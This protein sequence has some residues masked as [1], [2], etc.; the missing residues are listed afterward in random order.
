MEGQDTLKRDC[1]GNR[2]L[3]EAKER[4]VSPE[5]PSVARQRGE[6]AGVVQGGGDQMVLSDRATELRLDD[7]PSCT[8][9][10]TF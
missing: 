8:P 4:G 5:G 10:A 3:V 7:S 2:S 9:Q 6:G 1:R